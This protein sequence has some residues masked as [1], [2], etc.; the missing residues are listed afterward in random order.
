MKKGIAVFD[1]HHPHHNKVLWNNLLKLI[2]KEQP[3][4]F[5]LG[6]D[7]MNMDAV[8]HWKAEKGNKR[9]LEG[10][11]V[12]KEYNDFQSQIL[13]ELEKIL[14]KDCRKIFML[15][16]HE[17]WIEQYIDK[18]P[19]IEGYLEVKSNL[20]LDSWEFYEYGETPKTGKLLWHHGEYTNDNNAKKTVTTYFRNICYGHTHTYQAY[21]KISPNN[22]EAHSAVSLPCACDM[23]PDYMKNKSHRWVNGFGMFYIQDNGNFNLYPVIATKGHFVWSGDEY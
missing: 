21:T 9:A 15:G 18:N 20:R 6:G 23:Q 7:N 2:D 12:I 5:I 8:D 14:P 4:I 3:D 19:S 1:L 10:K 16:N 13:D 17:A 22:Q 11:R